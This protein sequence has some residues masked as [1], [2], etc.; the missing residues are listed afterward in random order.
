MSTISI[1]QNR[2]FNYQEG[3]DTSGSVGP[4]S[5]IDVFMLDAG[6]IK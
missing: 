5:R 2:L 6:H 1:T 4:L 3:C